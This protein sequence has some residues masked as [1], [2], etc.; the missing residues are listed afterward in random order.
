MFLASGENTP[1]PVGVSSSSPPNTAT[2]TGRGPSHRSVAALVRPTPRS[3][4]FGGKGFH[5]TGVLTGHVTAGGVI[6]RPIQ[7]PPP[8]ASTV[9]ALPSSQEAPS[10]LGGSQHRPLP[11]A[12]G[13]GS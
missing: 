1:S 8:H 5:N 4:W 7:T 12:P 10:G 9:H 11:R 6:S 3:V 2:P 13:P